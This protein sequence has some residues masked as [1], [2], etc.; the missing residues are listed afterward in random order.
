MCLQENLNDPDLLLSRPVSLPDCFEIASEKG[1][2]FHLTVIVRCLRT[3][4]KLMTRGTAAELGA[5]SS[6]S[7]DRHLHSSVSRMRRKN[8]THYFCIEDGGC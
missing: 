6:V 7:H 1:R 2:V 4:H 8:L 3:L 5:L